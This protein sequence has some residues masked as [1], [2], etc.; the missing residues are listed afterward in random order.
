MVRAGDR[1]DGAA[2]G[3]RATRRK[4]VGH[5][6]VGVAITGAFYLLL[7]DTTYPPELYVLA[8]VVFLGGVAYEAAREQGF[9]EV[10]L[11]LLALRRLPRALARVPGDLLRL[12]LMALAQLLDPR[13]GRGVLRAVPFRHGADEGR[14]AAGRR[15]LAEAVGSVSPNTIVIGIDVER[16]LML[17]HQ[18]RPS[19]GP[20]QIDPLELR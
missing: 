20:Q 5:W 13:G 16:D 7:I 2:G 12:T 14:R 1:G 8:F 11:P 6:L 19:G 17:V 10:S 15:A 3:I 18:L 9:A 4:R